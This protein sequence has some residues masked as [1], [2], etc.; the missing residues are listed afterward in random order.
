MIVDLHQQFDR[1]RFACP[2]R[3]AG[4][5]VRPADI[6]VGQPNEHRLTSEKRQLIAAEIERDDSGALSSLDYVTN[7]EY[8]SWHGVLESYR[9][10]AS[11]PSGRVQPRLQQSSARSLDLNFGGLNG[12]HR[13]DHGCAATVGAGGELLRAG[14]LLAE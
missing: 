12:R 10:R 5:G 3:R 13:A 14:V 7:G 4:N 9:T 11:T 8:K 6:A 2:G 1:P